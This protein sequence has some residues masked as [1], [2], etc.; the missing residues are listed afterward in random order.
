LNL[1]A[2]LRRRGRI[3]GEVTTTAAVNSGN[4][5]IGA[6]TG[7]L[8]ARG[9]GPTARGELVIASVGPQVIATLMICGIDEALVYLLARAQGRAERGRVLGSALAMAAILGLLAT[10][11]AALLQWVY[12]TPRLHA[13]GLA[14]AFIYASLP[15][16]YITTQVMLAAMRA[17]QRYSLWNRCRASIPIV[18]LAS[19]LALFVTHRLSASAVIMALYAANFALFVYLAA[20]L[21]VEKRLKV[22]YGDV[23]GVLRLGIQHHLISLGQLVNQR[24]DQLILTGLVSAT[25]LGYYAVAVTYASFALAVAL[26]PAWHLFSQASK[27]GRIAPERFRW[28]QR[29]TT[30]AMVVVAVLG[31]VGA[32]I[33]ITVVF[34]HVFAPAILP[35]V[36]LLA[37]GPPLALS[38]LRAAAWK[39]SGRP[40]PAALAEGIGVV[41]TVVGL[42]VFAS[43]F[44]II[45]AAYTSVVAYAVVTV[46]LFRVPTAP[47]VRGGATASTALSREAASASG[48]VGVDRDLPS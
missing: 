32:P 20:R 5:L 30:L 46:V 2:M 31:G 14:P 1:I 44:G 9:L 19:V 13:I 8:V 3:I 7:V 45:A 12:F 36:V 33:F 43:R 17:R 48:S 26:A 10:A 28:L 15:F 34:G 4:Q 35:A 6:A 29:R 24:I 37:G 38:A 39:A 23:V 47:V 27:H 11:V 18:Y 21:V 40:L 41:V 25:Q 16:L 42:S 22:T